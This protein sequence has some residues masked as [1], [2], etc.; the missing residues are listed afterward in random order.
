MPY[1]K[2]KFCNERKKYNSLQYILYFLHFC[3]LYMQLHGDDN[4]NVNSQ[5]KIQNNFN[6]EHVSFQNKTFPCL[7]RKLS[8]VYM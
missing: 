1:Y 3:I 4:N 5:N 2:L 6:K 7:S 8:R